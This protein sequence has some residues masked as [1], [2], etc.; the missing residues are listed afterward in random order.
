MVFTGKPIKIIVFGSQGNNIPNFAT[1]IEREM[2]GH[3]TL[4]TYPEN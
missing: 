4:Q 1:K 3:N 2:A